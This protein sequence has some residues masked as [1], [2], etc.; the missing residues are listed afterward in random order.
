MTQLLNKY[1]ILFAL[2][3]I[4][5]MGAA[6]QHHIAEENF[7]DTYTIIQKPSM[8][9]VG[10]ECRTSNAP[11]AGPV[12]IPKLWGQFYSENIMDQIP[13]KASNEVIALYCDYEGDHTQPYSLVIGCPV[14]SLH[15]VPEGM[16]A[17]ITPAASYAVF[18][19]VGEYP[20]SLIETWGA[21]WQSGLERT[22][23][24]DFE[25]YGD[26]FFSGSPQEVEV[27]IAVE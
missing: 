11:D 21:I 1:F 9:I 25:L 19:A 2:A 17:K 13:D 26:K 18:R 3:L 12:D 24:G 7:M 6:N 16:V 20:K 15:E 27:Y 23:T 22:Y 5:L 14:K 8:V 10:I 4:P